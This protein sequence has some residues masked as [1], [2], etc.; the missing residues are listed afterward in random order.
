MAKK[1]KK[2]TRAT[3]KA[4]AAAKA[5]KANGAIA[6]ADKVERAKYLE[7]HPVRIADSIVAAKAD[8]LAAVFREHEAALAERRDF[9]AQSREK[10]A[11]IHERMK[12]LAESVEKHTELRDVEVVE[13]LITAT[14]E[15]QCVR[16][17]TG[18]VVA[19]RTAD[20]DDRQEAL[21]AADRKASAE[22]NAKE[23]ARSALLHGEDDLDDIGEFVDCIGCDSRV[24]ADTAT[25][26]DKG[27]VCAK[28]MQTA[29]AKDARKK[30]SRRQAKPG[31]EITSPAELL[32]N[33]AG[34]DAEPVK[35]RRKKN[36][37]E[38]IVRENGE[39]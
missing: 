29:G 8:E 1:A 22:G 4:A 18:E 32:A 23:A 21:F 35:G 27:P 6:H 33:D 12:T 30:T 39:G 5:P 36:L 10:V 25:A 15:I 20:A 13:Y 24:R 19:S 26:S 17:D 3:K 37:A 7:Q 11:G 9:N 34:V 38:T 16:T 28:C 31:E 2:K 14:S